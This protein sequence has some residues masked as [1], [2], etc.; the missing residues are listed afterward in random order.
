MQAIVHIQWL[1]MLIH[2]LWEHLETFDKF[3]FRLNF[4][5]VGSHTIRGLFMGLFLDLINQFYKGTQKQELC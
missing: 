5:L 3:D 2:W 4:V 1:D